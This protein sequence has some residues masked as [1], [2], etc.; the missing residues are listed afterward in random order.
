MSPEMWIAGAH[1]PGR[2]GFVGVGAM[3]DFAVTR[4][5]LVSWDSNPV[6]V[7]PNKTAMTRMGYG[8]CSGHGRLNFRFR[9]TRVLD[10]GSQAGYNSPDF[11]NF[12]TH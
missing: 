12:F 1:G 9:L 2:A 6:D 10:V 3:W 7:G 5:G 11:S 4:P 8:R